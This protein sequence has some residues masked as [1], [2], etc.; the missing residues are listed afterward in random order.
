M[1]IR[2]IALAL[3]F[4]GTAHAQPLDGEWTVDRKASTITYHVV[5]KFHHV[6]GTS[7]QVEG[8]ARL[9]P[10][11][12]TQVAVRAAVGSFDSGN[13][14]RDA[15]MK[16]SVEAAR[17]PT[18][19]LKALADGVAIPK[20]FPTTVDK[21]FKAQ[22]LFHGIQKV[23]DIVVK[24]VFE[25]ATRVRATSNFAVS[26]DEFKVERPSLMFV[27]VADALGIDADL[28]FVRQP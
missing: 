17:F 4:L 28:I 7:R 18:V 9:F 2:I 19:E 12:K 15:H 1:R 22:V 11:D 27:K 14:N 6:S 16:E 10:N 23:M 13:V 24:L 21:T 3:L 25:S 5:H 26:L 8:T 20:R